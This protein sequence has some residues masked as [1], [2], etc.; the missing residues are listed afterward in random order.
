M[1]ICRITQN[2]QML[3][4]W[5]LCAPSSGFL[6]GLAQRLSP[7]SAS[8]DSPSALIPNF[9]AHPSP[10][11]SIR[12]EG[13]LKSM[14]STHRSLLGADIKIKVKNLLLINATPYNFIFFPLFCLDREVW[15]CGLMAACK[16]NWSWENIFK[17]GMQ[18]WAKSNVNNFF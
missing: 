4:P 6:G 10:V 15:K 17:N 7:A 3:L 11:M 9:V 1:W 16:R 5:V 14:R 2:G 13:I 18:E 12:A 8:T